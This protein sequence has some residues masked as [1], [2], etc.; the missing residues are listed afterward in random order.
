MPDIPDYPNDPQQEV[1]IQ[2][3][4]LQE[5]LVALYVQKGMFRA[6]AEIAAARQIE[7]DLRGIQSHGSRA[8]PRYLAAMDRGDID[9]RGQTLVVK[10]TPAIAV[11]DGGRNLGHVA[12]TKAMHMAIEMARA[13]G[14]GTVGV[15]NSQHFGAAAVYSLMA[16]EAGMIGYCT[17]STGPAT[18]AA[19]GSRRPGTANNAFAWAA[20]LRAGSPFCLD[21]ACAVSSWGKVHSLGLYGRNIPPDWALDA[22]G[23]PTEI[24]ADAKTL[25][26]A[27]GPR[28]Y[29]LAFL[30]SILAGPLV[31]GRMPLHK[32]RTPEAEGSEH[33]FYAIDISQFGDPD[34]YYDEIEKTAAELRSLAARPGFERVTLPGELECERATRCRSEGIPLHRDHL[35]EL[36]ETAGKMKVAFP[37]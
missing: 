20:P 34:S 22:E 8:T 10:K 17:T 21:M 6:E 32:T 13:V 2:A 26:P 30:C 35:R 4:P 9:P 23:N 27:A 1:I 11:L 37:W 18:V 36:G 28:G 33:F 24:P 31:G 14:T 15:F 5:L 19:Y 12:S 3:E 7:A 16:A 29:G 25:L